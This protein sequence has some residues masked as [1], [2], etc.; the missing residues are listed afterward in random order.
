MARQPS[1]TQ[2]RLGEQREYVDQR[3][4]GSRMTR[5]DPAQE[6]DRESVSLCLLSSIEGRGQDRKSVV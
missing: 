1:T 5:L 2:R 4:T 6:V 3:D